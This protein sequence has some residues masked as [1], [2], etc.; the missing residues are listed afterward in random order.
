MRKLHSSLIPLYARHTPTV[1]STLAGLGF[2]LG[3]VT[4]SLTTTLPVF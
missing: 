1:T 4:L 3:L 2:G